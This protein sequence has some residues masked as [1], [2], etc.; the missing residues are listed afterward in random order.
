MRNQTSSKLGEALSVLV[1]ALSMS[2]GLIVAYDYSPLALK[3]ASDLR[4]SYTD[5]GLLQTCLFVP[6]MILQIPAGLLADRYS[7]KRLILLSMPLMLLSAALFALSNSESILLFSR[8]LSGI[9]LGM[10]FVPVIRYLLMSIG[11]FAPGLSLGILASMQAAGSVVASFAPAILADM[12]GSWRTAL[13]LLASPL[14]LLFFLLLPIKESQTNTNRLSVTESVKGILSNKTSWV[15]GFDNFVRFGIVLLLTTWVPSYLMDRF[16]Y[17]LLPASETLGIM[18]I[19][20]AISSLLGG[21]ITD[22]ERGA[23]YVIEAGLLL[24]SLFLFLVP[25]ANSSIITEII[26]PILGGAMYLAFSPMFSLLPSLIGRQ[27]PGFVSGVQNTFA[28]FGAAVFPFMMG[29]LRD[30]TG[31][32]DYGWSVSA[33]LTLVAALVS[34][35]LSSSLRRGV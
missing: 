24:T 8:V 27:N 31:G 17:Q 3:I 19:M 35:Q 13:M 4:L 33:L 1:L 16:S 29:Y 7:S 9:S 6:F 2:E 14:A 23:F 30:I 32:F 22:K 18:W 12:T 21:Y 26:L 10:M 25:R 11:G 28:T 34:M 20:A 5:I 15:L